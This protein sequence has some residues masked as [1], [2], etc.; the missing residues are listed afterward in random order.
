MAEAINPPFYERSE[1]TTKY[2]VDWG[3]AIMAGLV[4]TVLITVSM[5]L[6]GMNI[7]KSLG[8]MILGPS[9]NT[10]TQYLVG[11]SIH[12]MVG[13]GYGLIYAPLFG[14]VRRWGAFMKG[15][16]FGLAITAIAL[17]AMP[18]MASMMGGGAANPCNPCNAKAA[19]TNPCNP[20]Q[21][22]KKDNPCNPCADKKSASAKGDA[23]TSAK[24]PCNPCQ[25]KN[26]CNP[27]GGSDGNPY[28]ASVSLINHLIYGLA[29]ALVYRRGRT[30]VG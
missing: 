10:I 11:G 29:L 24:N 2:H 21:A 18:V 14:P 27:C 6:F 19:A 28:A 26:P 25:A 20:C 22:K 1:G 3:R 15:L 8:G 7:M 16:V 5:A 4:A 13:L 9:A 12:L 30:T 23:Q 17:A